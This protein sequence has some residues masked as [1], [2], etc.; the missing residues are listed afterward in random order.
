MFALAV[1]KKEPEWV[2]QRRL[3]AWRVFRDTPKPT[4]KDEPWRRTDI[5]RLKLERVAPATGGATLNDLPSRLRK[6]IDAEEGAGLT[7]HAD[8]GVVQVLEMV[9]F[10]PGTYLAGGYNRLKTEVSGREIENEDLV[11]WP[12]WLCLTFRPEGGDWFDPES[13]EMLEYRQELDLAF[14]V[15][16]RSMRF[17][18]ADGRET[19]LRSRR[20]VDMADM[21]YAAIEWTLTPEN[22]S[23]RVEVRSALDGRVTN[24][25]VVRYRELN[26]QH[27]EPIR[28]DTFGED[29]ITLLV[30]TVQSRIEMAQAARTRI[31]A[32]SSPAGVS[33]AGAS[34]RGLA[35]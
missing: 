5:R 13:V 32:G 19:T 6:M 1:S 21:H 26:S 33:S 23:G 15:L 3:E 9:G 27:L 35:P 8:G 12:N 28:T 11:N 10:E 2:K 7:L 25:G 4:T 18:D 29:G 16:H 24:A 20:L 22:W 14:A 31:L 30:Q 17:R 34:Y